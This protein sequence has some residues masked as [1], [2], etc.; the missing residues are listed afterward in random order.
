M[1]GRRRRPRTSASTTPPTPAAASPARCS[2]GCSISGAGSATA[3]AARRRCCSP[4]GSS[5]SCCRPTGAKFG[6]SAARPESIGPAPALRWR[7]A[8]QVTLCLL[9]DSQGA[10]ARSE[11][12]QS[13][14]PFGLLRAVGRTSSRLRGSSIEAS[15]EAAPTIRCSSGVCTASVRRSRGSS[16]DSPD[17]S[18]CSPG[19]RARQKGSR[20]WQAWWSS[21]LSRIF[22]AEG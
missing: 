6:P 1:P 17:D 19:R 16:R 22:P 12:M 18:T 4:A 21:G 13:G 9:H 10:H 20:R 2:P 15:W 11:D 3:S 8:P 5:P 14:I 7:K